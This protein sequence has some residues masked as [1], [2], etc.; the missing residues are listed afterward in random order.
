MKLKDKVLL[1]PGGLGA[2]GHT[3]VPAFTA[4]G[5]RVFVAAHQSGAAPSDL[6]V[7]NADVTDEAEVQWLVTEVI[8]KA[9]RIDGLINL[10][11]AFAPGHVAETPCRSGSGC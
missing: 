7:L 5:A 3:V 2:L 11:G 1:I 4:E 6:S 8:S 9:G 10:V